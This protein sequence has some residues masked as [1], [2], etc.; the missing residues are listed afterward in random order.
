VYFSGNL[1]W[2]GIIIAS[3]DVDFSGGGGGDRN[4]YGAVLAGSVAALYGSMSIQYSSC[5]VDNATS[6]GNYRISRW[7][8][9]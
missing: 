2:Y 9:L 8:Q 3:G 1:D 5:E 6:S 4:V 7:E